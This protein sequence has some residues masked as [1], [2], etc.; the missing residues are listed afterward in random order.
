MSKPPTRKQQIR[1]GKFLQKTSKLVYRLKTNGVKQPAYRQ[2]IFFDTD[3]GRVRAL[4]YGFEKKEITPVFF[5][6]HGGGF[7][8]G[9]AV[10]DEALNLEFVKQV[11]CKVISIEYAKAPQYPYPTAVNQVYALVKHVFQNA[12]EFG[13]N[14]QK[15]AIGGHSAGGNLSTVACMLAKKEGLF[16]FVC[17]VLDYPPLDLATSPFEKPQPKGCIPPKM[18]RLFNDCYATAQQA[19]EPYASPVFASLDDL[20]GLPPALMIVA[21]M[22]SLHAEGLKYAGMLQE[23]GVE[24]EIHDYPEA[25]HGFTLN[26][27]DDARDAVEKMAGFLARW[28]N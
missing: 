28:L 27:S 6:L 24:V 26:Q 17:Q 14:P 4:C 11:G 13:I 7:I 25:A 22:D 8:L 19:R 5:D 20:Q 12:E 1:K 16:Q 3:F 21:G 15:M 23:A 18:A 2:E 10:M 9:G